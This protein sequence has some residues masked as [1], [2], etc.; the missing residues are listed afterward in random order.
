LKVAQLGE[1]L[2]RIER[3]SGGPESFVA[4]ARL[5]YAR[6]G[7]RLKGTAT[8][9]C[10][11]PGFLRYEIQG[12]HG[13]VLE[14]FAT[15]GKEFQVAKLAEGRFLYGPARAILLNRLL[16]FAPLSLDAAGWVDLLFGRI[17]IPPSASWRYE[18]QIGRFV[19]EFERGEAAMRVEVVPETS[20]IS[21]IRSAIEGES[22]WEVRI[23]EWDP[24]GLP[25]EMGFSAPGQGVEGRI[26]LRD[27]KVG[28]RLEDSLFVLE[29][30]EGV[31]SEYRG[32]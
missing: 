2:E 25:A 21:R 30:P 1:L 26:K 11:R 17:A 22:P 8:L 13:G 3:T 23:S 19:V 18:P 29:P 7:R 10:R 16:P 24:S 6:E 9:A 15:N 14:A 12:P 4:E 20:R 31:I 27:I 5:T 32:S 28:Q